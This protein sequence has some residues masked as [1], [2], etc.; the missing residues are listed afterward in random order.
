MRRGL[1]ELT[2]GH[3]DE[4]VVWRLRTQT[5][6]GENEGTQESVRMQMARVGDSERA[7]IGWARVLASMRE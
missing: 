2:R 1:G 4:Q 6:R 3:V 7:H 5:T